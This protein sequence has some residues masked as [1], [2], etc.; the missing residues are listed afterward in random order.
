VESQPFHVIVIGAGAA[1]HFAVAQ[2]LERFPEARILILEKTG[3]TLSKVRISGGGRCNVTHNCTDPTKL[4]TFYPRGN[5]WLSSVFSGFSVSDTLS[6]FEKRGVRI[7]AEEDGRMFPSTNTSETIVE[8]LS[9]AAK[10]KNTILRLHAGV[11]NMFKTDSGFRVELDSGE[12][13][14]SE[15]VVV[16]SGGSPSENGFR[17]LSAFN[18]KVV[19]PV[20]SLFTFNVPA[21]PWAD[22]KGLSV[23]KATVR[24][25]GSDLQFTGPVLVTHWGFSGPAVLKLSA[26]AARVLHDSGYKYAFRIDWLPDQPEAEVIQRMVDF[27]SQNP[28]KK[29]DQSPVFEIPKR[30]W[31]QICLESGLSTHFNWAEVGKKK[32]LETAKLLKGRR[33]LAEGKTT[34]K[35]EF[36][37][38]GGIDLSEVDPKTCGSVRFPG[39]FFA[40]EILDVDGV[41]GGFNFQAAW[42]TAN[43]A[44]V[45]IARTL[46]K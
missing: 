37:T 6:W 30:L 23:Q 27:N 1:G 46:R 29:P 21:H 22:L 26:F 34:Y 35:E 7:V 20:P 11:K 36:V 4:L 9:G 31:E 42:S 45:E 2:I 15:K 40:G 24:L 38:A 32:I 28:K 5:P 41:T 13:L 16:S 33:F 44:A 19:P 12:V 8:T 17:F 25:E 43:G 3:K 18:F 10:G 14:E 39:L